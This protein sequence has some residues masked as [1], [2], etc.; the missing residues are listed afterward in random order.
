M[1]PGDAPHLTLL[2]AMSLKLREPPK[3]LP[4][5][6]PE[7]KV[8]GT[9]P[10]KMTKEGQGTQARPS[11]FFHPQLG[12]EFSSDPTSPKTPILSGYLIHLVEHN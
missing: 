9:E 2:G 6:V 4:A 10:Y 1:P 12:S 3:Q 8:S 11:P 7:T 5:R